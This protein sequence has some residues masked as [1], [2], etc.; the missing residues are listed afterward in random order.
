MIMHIGIDSPYCGKNWRYKYAF[1]EAPHLFSWNIGK[2]GPLSRPE[3]EFCPQCAIVSGLMGDRGRI[4]ASYGHVSRKNVGTKFEDLFTLLNEA[5]D[6]GDEPPV[7]P[8]LPWN[9]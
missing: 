4:Y 3:W 7:L 9:S 6:Q 1:M 2:G 8:L 5:R